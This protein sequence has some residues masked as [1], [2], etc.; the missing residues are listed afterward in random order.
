MPQDQVKLVEK[1]SAKN[2]NTV[3]VLFCGA[4][5]ETSWADKVKAIL[6]MGLPGQA[7]GSG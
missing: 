2:P 4:P 6:Y 7:G 3:V 5:V 1:T